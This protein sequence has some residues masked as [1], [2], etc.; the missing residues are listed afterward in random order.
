M[1]NFYDL[2]FVK[3]ERWRQGSNFIDKD[4]VYDTNIKSSF[5]LKNFRNEFNY[6]IYILTLWNVTICGSIPWQIHWP[7]HIKDGAS[8]PPKAGEVLDFDMEG[9]WRE[10]EKLVKENLVRD[11]GI[12]NFSLKK[13]NKLLGFAQ[14][15]PSVCQVMTLH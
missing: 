15:T 13:L 4:L 8:R 11:I 7:F 3:C 9:V 12:S 10:M 6:F 1:F 14:T 2:F 5:I